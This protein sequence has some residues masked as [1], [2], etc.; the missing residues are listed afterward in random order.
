MEFK[1]TWIQIEL[2]EK[3]FTKEPIQGKATQDGKTLYYSGL[4]T[5]VDG[6]F[7]IKEEQIIAYE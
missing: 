2:V 5:A 3:S 1:N 7:F 6:K 4:P